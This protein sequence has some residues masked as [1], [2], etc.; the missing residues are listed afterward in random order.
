MYNPLPFL[1]KKFQN[2][3][4]NLK[5]SGFPARLVFFITGLLATI[6]FLV[7]VIPKPSRVH[8][9]CVQAT[10]P[11]MSGFVLYLGGSIGTFSLYRQFR[12]ISNLSL[13]YMAGLLLLASV[14]VFSF[15][16]VQRYSH[17]NPNMRMTLSGIRSFPPNQ[18]IGQAKGIFPGRVVWMWDPKSTNGNCTNSSNENGVIDAGDDAWF[19]A[20]NSN[21]AVIDSM[22]IKSLIGLTGKTNLGK[23]WDTIF[24]FY[25]MAHGNGNTGYTAGQRIFIKINETS[26]YGG[27]AEGRFNADLGRTDHLAVSDFV[28][29]TNP[30]VVLSVLRQLV[31]QAHVPEEMIYVGDPARNVYKEFFNLWHSEFPAVHILGN[32]LIHTEID[33]V[34]LGRTPVAVTATDRV[35]F[36]D[37]GTVMPLAVTDKLFT[38]F[39]S[40][41][42]LINIPALK[43]H[44]SAGITLAAK[45]HFGSFTREWAM[46]LH[47]GLMDSADYPLRQGYGLYRVQTDIMSHKLLGGKTMLIIVD[48]LYPGEDALGVPHKW[49]S[50]PFN[51]NWC[52]S[53]FM[54]LDP[55]AV[56]SVCHDFLRSEYFG[57][58]YATSRP[59]WYGVDD[60]L[61]QAAD[62]SL[63]PKGIRYDPDKDNILFASLGTHEH[64]NDSLH[65]Q[66]SRNLGTGNGIELYRAHEVHLGIPGIISLSL[67][68]I[69]PNPVKDFLYLTNP[70][71]EVLGYAIADLHGNVLLSGKTLPNPELSI[72]LRNL[73]PGIYILMITG[74]TG[75]MDIKL[76]K[77]NSD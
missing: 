1:P 52:S 67:M 25:N 54:S 50:P 13:S 76:I 57:T 49:K 36:S 61:R 32:N 12:T 48:G 44:A 58:T 65:K 59:N 71:S 9:P 6:W 21:I 66:Y 29:E 56:E 15:S 41:D 33:V 45:N 28:S 18:P 69:Y 72:D 75:S 40:A 23:A 34:G 62:S 20:A 5:K 11:F 38:I 39:D 74:R 47:K 4:E 30:Y 14:L 73:K 10:A 7:R 3:I 8:Y 35:F 43:A 19:M 51:N 31:H 2:L 24:R 16:G 46:H 77:Q 53:L 17:S 64:W 68:K 55:V 63:W 27:I 22:M 26:A 42:Y 70:A 37:H 60:Y